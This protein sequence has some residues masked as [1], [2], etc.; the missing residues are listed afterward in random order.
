M[1]GRRRGR[2]WLSCGCLFACR[3]ISTQGMTGCGAVKGSQSPARGEG[4]LVVERAGSGRLSGRGGSQARA[5]AGWWITFLYLGTIRNSTERGSFS[6]RTCWCLLLHRGTWVISFSV[7]FLS[8]WFLKCGKTKTQ[9]IC[10]KVVNFNQVVEYNQKV[11]Q[12]KCCQFFSPLRLFSILLDK[13]SR[14][15]HDTF[16]DLLCT[17]ASAN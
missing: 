5:P 12:L 14:W 9:S 6:S 2:N 10:T 11:R 3:S 7:T 1:V 17:W 15:G 16:V 8:S 4:E 13:D